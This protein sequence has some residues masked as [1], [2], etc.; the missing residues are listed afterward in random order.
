MAVF[1]LFRRLAISQ[2]VSQFFP[3]S[4]A[5]FFNHSHASFHCPLPGLDLPLGHETV[6]GDRFAAI[7]WMAKVGGKPN[8]EAA[9]KFRNEAN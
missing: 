1:V 4:K 2:P 3:H 5:L 8:L 6:Y 7:E 9:E